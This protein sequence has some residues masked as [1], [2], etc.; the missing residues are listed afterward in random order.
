[1]V[2]P[3]ASPNSVNAS[4]IAPASFSES[5]TP[6]TVTEPAVPG[7]GVEG[8]GAVLPGAVVAASDAA[9]VSGASVP[10]SVVPAAV[11]VVALSVSTG[12]ATDSSPPASSSSDVLHAAATSA[13]ANGTAHSR[14]HLLLIPSP[15]WTAGRQAR[16]CKR[17]QVS[18]AGSSTHLASRATD[19]QLDRAHVVLQGSGL[20]AE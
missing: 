9:V 13:S 8:S 16:S 14:T 11:E 12:V 17:F 7:P 5:S 4:C 3:F 6:N 19:H 20:P 15:L 10:S 1:M 18:P 2:M